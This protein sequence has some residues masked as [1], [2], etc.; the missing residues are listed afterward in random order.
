MSLLRSAVLSVSLALGVAPMTYAQ[1][2]QFET[3]VEMFADFSDY[4]LSNETLVI[5][6]EK[7]L[8]LR[9]AKP[10]YKGDPE[11]LVKHEL[12]RAV[13]YGIYKTFIHTDEPQVTVKAV[14]ILVKSYNPLQEEV[15][16]E[17]VY[18]ISITREQA[19]EALQAMLPG[20]DFNSIVEER[21]GSW[22]WNDDFNSLYYEDRDPG[23][24]AFY[25]EVEKAA[26]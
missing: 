21:A 12:H 10:V 11:S 17:P 6:N 4:S 7:P 25:E 8:E 5:L 2:T 26:R 13:L 23:L 24:D 3:A 15:L 16:D 22:L 9:L 20:A 1:P 18:E 14:P 19:L